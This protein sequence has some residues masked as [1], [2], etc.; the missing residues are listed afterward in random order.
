MG[1]PVNIEEL[2]N[3]RTVE[4]ER[5]EFKKGWNPLPILHSI[6]AFANDLN[7]WGGGYIIIGIK[8]HNGRPVLPP[9]GIEVSRVDSIQKNLLEMCYRLRPHYF[10]IV[11]PVDFQDRKIL[12][13]WVPGG[14]NRPY[15]TPENLANG[16]KYYPYIRRYSTTKRASL[17]E[18]RELISLANI[19]PFD[20]QINHGAD[21][22]DLNLTLIQS[23]LA[24][25][26]SGLM[27]ELTNLSFSDLCRRMNIVEGPDE[28]L[29]PKNVGLLMFNED[30]KRF[31]RGAQIDVVLFHDEVGDRF[32]EKIFTG[33]IQQQVISALL[34]IKNNIITESVRKVP[35][36]AEAIRFFNYPYE[37]IDES[38]V[39]A[40]YHRSYQDDSPVEVRIFPNRIEILSYPGP[41]PPLNKDN[42]MNENITVR[43]YRNR[44]IGDFFKE[45]HLTE[46]RSTGFPKIRRALEVNGSPGPTFETDEDR[47]YFLT[48]LKAH[49]EAY[50]EAHVEAQVKAHVEL[51]DTQITILSECALTPLSTQE[52]VRLLGHSGIS[53]SIKKAV[54]ELRENDLIAFTI[55]EKPRSRSQKYRI[56]ESGRAALEYYVKQ[57]GMKNN[58]SN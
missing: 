14:A 51:S 36:Q 41:L 56:T 57:G 37:A 43:R 23:H 52:I 29:K 30:P 24:E 8:E 32:T 25:I 17:E 21:I 54:T 31:F 19:I 7:N 49:P 42:L 47:S 27:Q 46:G 2:I 35:G 39:N 58:G 15:T 50:V 11:E 16:S 18:E 6:C 5:I 10:P 1:L 45:L 26:K 44:R 34:Y 53:G 38:L 40:V 55:P 33:P 12:I 48:T 13:I 22:L 3:G 4:W 28:Y 9:E 20:D